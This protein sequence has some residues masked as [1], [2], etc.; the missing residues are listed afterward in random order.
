MKNNIR[1]AGTSHCSTRIWLWFPPWQR[2]VDHCWCISK[3]NGV[4]KCRGQS[5]S[6]SYFPQTEM[7]QREIDPG[8]FAA[9]VLG[10]NPPCPAVGYWQGL[11]CGWAFSCWE[12]LIN[13]QRISYCNTYSN[14]VS[15]LQFFCCISTRPYLKLKSSASCLISEQRLPNNALIYLRT[16]IPGLQDRVSVYHNHT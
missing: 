8:T 12:R 7:R 1:P 13:F 14:W 2:G 11:H 6:S 16:V 9:F 3:W 10:E 15:C 4:H 5:G